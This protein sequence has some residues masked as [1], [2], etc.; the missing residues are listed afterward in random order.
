MKRQAVRFTVVGLSG[1]A[2]QYAW[3]YG[4]LQL[5]A[6]LWPE[7]ELVNTA[8]TLG[9]IL[10]MISNYLLT[11]YYTFGQRPGWKN[12]GGFATARGVNYVLQIAL[13]HI[14]LWLGMTN[15]VAGIVSIVI[16][17]VINFFVTRIFFKEKHKQ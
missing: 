1:T 5:F 15:E 3:Y 14:C 11:S 12:L 13:L 4:L 8:F 6:Y 9:Y 2:V 7:V 17:G 10:E 16:A